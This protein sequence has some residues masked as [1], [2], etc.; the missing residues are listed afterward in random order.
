MSYFKYKLCN[1]FAVQCMF[2][3]LKL[4]AQCNENKKLLEEIER[5]AQ[6]SKKKEEV[7]Q[8]EKRM[9]I[10]A[11]ASQCGEMSSTYLASGKHV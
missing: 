1:V 4:K 9:F 7:F 5:R 10:E 6:E 8:D 2:L 11:M 3:I